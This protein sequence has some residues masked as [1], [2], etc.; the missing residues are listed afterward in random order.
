MNNWDLYLLLRSLNNNKEIVTA[1]K[2]NIQFEELESKRLR[3]TAITKEYVNDIFDIYF[4]Y[5]VIRYTDSNL[6]FSKEDT[7]KFIEHLQARMQ[8]GEA[9]YW[10]L[11]HKELNKIIGTLGLYHIDHKHSFAS[12]GCILGKDYWRQ[13]YMSEAFK[14]IIPFS[15]SKIKLHRIEAQMY[16]HHEAS[17]SLFEKLRFSREAK[18]RENFQIEWK[19]EDSYLYTLIKS[20]F[21]ELQAFYK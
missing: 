5:D 11:F 6:H 16:I 1:R 21:N 4:D 12:V 2:L 18:L 15:F 3:L 7:E 19:Q 20:D 13:G 10:G 14:K 9:I 17:I 8:I